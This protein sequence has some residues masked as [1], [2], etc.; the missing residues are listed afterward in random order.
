MTGASHQPQSLTGQAVSAGVKCQIHSKVGS[1]LPCLT[2]GISVSGAAAPHT[3]PRAGLA[4]L[5]ISG[6]HLA[7]EFQT[8][9]GNTPPSKLNLLPSDTEVLIQYSKP[10]APAGNLSLYAWMELCFTHTEMTHFPAEHPELSFISPVENRATLRC[11][12]AH[13][14]SLAV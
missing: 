1:V 8:W 11:L 5:L 6:K 2:R 7:A 13:T 3:S 10:C 9:Q 12:C 14:S 4:A